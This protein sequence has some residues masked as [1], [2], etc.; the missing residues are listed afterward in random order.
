MTVTMPEIRVTETKSGA[1]PEVSSSRM[2]TPSVV[3]GGA[4]VLSTPAA[5]PVRSM[6]TMSGT[7]ARAATPTTVNIGLARRRAWGQKASANHCATR[8]IAA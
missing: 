2:W 1:T 4:L 8:N 7:Y 5:A 6:R 3:E